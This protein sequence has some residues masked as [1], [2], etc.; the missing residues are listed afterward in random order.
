MQIALLSRF[1]IR[2]V[3]AIFIDFLVKTLKHEQIKQFES[4]CKLAIKEDMKERALLLQI[5]NA[6]LQVVRVRILIALAWGRGEV[7]PGEGVG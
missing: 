2:I 4:F 3:I 5:N 7:G 6:E 1:L